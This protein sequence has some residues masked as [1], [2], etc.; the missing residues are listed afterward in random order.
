MPHAVRT[1]YGNLGALSAILRE[2]VMNE[3][4]YHDRANLGM[5]LL[6]VMVTGPLNTNRISEECTFG[7]GFGGI[8]IGEASKSALRPAE[9][10]LLGFPN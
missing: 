8:L 6:S 1:R 7:S 3:P 10:R 9:G 2:L 4:T 5:Q